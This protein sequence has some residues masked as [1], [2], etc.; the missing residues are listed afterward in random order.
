MP[1]LPHDVLHYRSVGEG[2][3][4]RA[5]DERSAQVKY[6][7]ET[8]GERCA[9]K[10]DELYADFVPEKEQIELLTE[11]AGTG[12]VIEIGSGTGRIALP[13][14]ERVPVI[15]VDA[16]RDMTDRLI[17]KVD[18]LPITP[19][20]AD[21]ADYQAEAPVDLVCILFNTFFLLKSETTQRAFL[22]N[23]AGMLSDEGT[24][25]IETFV[26]R[27]GRRLPDGPYPG[28]FPE[29][30][31]VVSLK[32]QSPSTVVLFTAENHTENQEFHYNEIVLRDGEPLRVLPGQMR[33]WYPEQ[34]D[35][36]AAE[37]GLSLWKRWADWHRT[38]YDR[39]NSPKHIS[40]YR[41][42]YHRSNP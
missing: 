38:P 10:Y 17:G 40:L 25:L 20:T 19:V 26:P 1:G 9:D 6:T 32:R 22:R 15:A 16:A 11:L 41:P 13:L 37:A 4:V 30:R 36:L 28:M 23:T 31:A 34:I 42:A 3:G 12:P 5:P 14:A 35:D 8:Y 21:A 24:L 39:A 33:Y 27:P 2:V 29:E 18:T 7:S